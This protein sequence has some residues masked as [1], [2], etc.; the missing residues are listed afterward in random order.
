MILKQSL[1]SAGL[2]LFVG[3]KVF[4]NAGFQRGLL[5]E[6]VKKQP[7]Q[8][9]LFWRGCLLFSYYERYRFLLN[10]PCEKLP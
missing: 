4:F 5:G 7:R 10:V 8:N 3:W 1:I 2:K 9:V 6:L